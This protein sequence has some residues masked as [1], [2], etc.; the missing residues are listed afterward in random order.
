[1]ATSNEVLQAGIRVGKF[2]VA[3]GLIDISLTHFPEHP[4]GRMMV[5]VFGWEGSGFQPGHFSLN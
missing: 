4:K 5:L 2:I 1:M 3:H